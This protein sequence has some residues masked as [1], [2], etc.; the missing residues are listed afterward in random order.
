MF[1]SSSSL[2]RLKLAVLLMLA[3]PLR[4]RNGVGHSYFSIWCPVEISDRLYTRVRFKGSGL[5]YRS[6]TGLIDT[7][8]LL[9]QVIIKLYDCHFIVIRTIE[10][11]Y[12]IWLVLS[13]SVR[14]ALL[15]QY[16][17]IVSF[18][19]ASQPPA[20]QFPSCSG[21]VPAAASIWPSRYFDFVRPLWR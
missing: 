17:Q 11:N 5:L 18:L 2:L 3:T 21:R 8:T 14:K 1:L 19:T 15:I 13:F 7:C 16:D 12:S 20:W 10:T 6:Y 4:R 9:I